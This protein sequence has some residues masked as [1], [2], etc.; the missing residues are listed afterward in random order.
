MNTLQKE[1]RRLAGVLKYIV[2]RSRGFA[3]LMRLDDGNYHYAS[4]AHRDD[5]RKVM[6]EWLSR[7]DAGV[8]VRD[9]SE[10]APD[11]RNR[12]SLE[13]ECAE[14]GLLLN[15]KGHLAVLFLF[16]F[17]DRGNLAWHS[18]APDPKDVVRSFLKKIGAT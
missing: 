15:A 3:L 7:V 8:N 16:D 10:T 11:M 9:P 14:L 18:S 1:F 17:G 12:V 2:G 4:T 6:E 13:S 5:V